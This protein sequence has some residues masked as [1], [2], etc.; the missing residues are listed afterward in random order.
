MKTRKNAVAC[1]P[2]ALL[3]I[4]SL[5][6]MMATEHGSVRL[7]GFGV[8]SSERLYVGRF[9]SIEVYEDTELIKKIDAPTSRGWIMTVSEGDHIIVSTGEKIY[10]MDLEGN[11]IDEG[12]D[13]RNRI[14]FKIRDTRK[15][16]SADGSIYELKYPLGW[17]Q[18]TK[19]DITIYRIPLTDVW[20]KISI[21]FAP[22]LM[23][24][25]L[26]ADKNRRETGNSTLS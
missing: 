11:I 20:M 21:V 5:L 12:P 15:I 4:V 26:L 19:D 18:I 13:V 2:I 23:C 14:Y 9:H 22:V 3:M 24:I 6:V 10:T 25:G 16:E 17:T 7:E 8:D 1:V